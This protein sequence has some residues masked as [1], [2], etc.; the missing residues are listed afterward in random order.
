MPILPPAPGAVFEEV[1]KICAWMVTLVR[2]AVVSPS[3]G[4]VVSTRGWHDKRMA[5]MNAAGRMP[6][7][8]LVLG[9]LVRTP[10]LLVGDW[11]AARSSKSRLGAWP[12]PP[13]VF[14]APPSGGGYRLHDWLAWSPH[15]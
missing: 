15:V 9:Y 3:S 8:E 2:R 10:T 13:A 5:I 1:P 11:D 6:A 7:G 12:P 4:D 14:L